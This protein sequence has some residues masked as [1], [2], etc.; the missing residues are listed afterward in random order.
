MPE[1]A[2]AS[3]AHE[4]ISP[5]PTTQTWAAAKRASGSAVE[6]GDAAE[7]AVN[8]EIRGGS[9]GKVRCVI[10]SNNWKKCRQTAPSALYCKQ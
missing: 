3:T 4:P 6:A 2:S 5:T 7:A 10:Q 8:R 1:R 9:E